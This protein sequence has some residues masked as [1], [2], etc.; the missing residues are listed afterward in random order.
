MSSGS[1]LGATNATAFN[2]W[3]ALLN[4]AGSPLL[5]VRNCSDATGVSGFAP[6]GLLSTIAEGGAGAADSVK[7]NYA[8]SA[9]TNKAFVIAAYANY[10][11]GLTTAGTWAASPTRMVQ[12][13]PGVPLPGA[14]VQLVSATG[15]SSVSTTSTS[16]VASACSSFHRCQGAPPIC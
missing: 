16:F 8:A 3:I 2:V 7:T 1:T 9:V 5:A 14:S 6:N 13:G 10:E 15:G 12:F 11:S 4:N